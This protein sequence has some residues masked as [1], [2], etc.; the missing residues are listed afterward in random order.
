MKDRIL[1][2]FFHVRE[3]RNCQRCGSRMKRVPR[4]RGDRML[5]VFIPVIRCECCG[6]SVLVSPEDGRY[7][8]KVTAR[9]SAA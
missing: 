2:K 6:Q 5:S 3:S 1:K 9:R 8:L 4:T 7:E